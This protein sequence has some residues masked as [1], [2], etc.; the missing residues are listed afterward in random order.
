MSKL[1]TLVA[2]VFAGNAALAS[3]PIQCSDAEAVMRFIG[4]STDG[5]QAFSRACASDPSSEPCMAFN[6]GIL[7][8][9]NRLQEGDSEKLGN[10]ETWLRQECPE[11]SY[12]QG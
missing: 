6:M 12:F 4:M 10:Y 5:M 2:L 8:S 7:D 1:L 11:I 3:Q 9:P